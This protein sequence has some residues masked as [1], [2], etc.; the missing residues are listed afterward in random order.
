MI[1]KLLCECQLL[2][3]YNSRWFGLGVH[4]PELAAV[5]R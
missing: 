3:V 5:G 1:P 2:G 4:D